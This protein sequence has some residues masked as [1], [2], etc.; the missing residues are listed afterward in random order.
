MK[1]KI[2]NVRVD[3]ELYQVITNLSDR[4]SLTVSE[5]VRLAITYELDKFSKQKSYTKEE[6]LGIIDGLKDVSN[7]V[8]KLE[9]Q[10]IKMGTN[11][12]QLAKYT[13]KVKD[14]RYIDSNQDYLKSCKDNLIKLQ[15]ELKDISC[16]AWGVL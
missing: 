4:Y 11:I 15:G 9:T 16:K 1:N 14:S 10:I 2:I 13:N 12:N 7:S 8:N 3:D 6:Y 5:I